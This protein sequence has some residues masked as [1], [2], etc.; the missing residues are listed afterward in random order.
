MTF[1]ADHEL[2]YFGV[3]PDEIERL[4]DADDEQRRKVVDRELRDLMSAPGGR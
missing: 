3:D 2:E 4:R 1:V